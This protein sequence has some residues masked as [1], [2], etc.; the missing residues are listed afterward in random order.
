[1]VPDILFVA[2]KREE[3]LTEK[4]VQGPPD[5][6][7]EVLSP[8]SRRIDEVRKYRLYQRTGV[9]EY[10]VVDPRRNRVT[11]HRRNRRRGGLTRGNRGFADPLVLA[12][13]ADQLTTPLL[14]GFSASL[15]EVFPPRPAS[16]GGRPK[17]V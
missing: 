13:P 3:I 2:A 17:A 10:W 14:P 16:P 12:A 8:G 1:V 6:M 9:Q 5:L 7:V 11:I 15:S 4:N